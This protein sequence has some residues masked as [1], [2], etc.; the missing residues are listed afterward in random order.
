MLYT[1]LVRF[2]IPNEMIKMPLSMCR[3][4]YKSVLTATSGI[5]SAVL[6]RM[7]CVVKYQKFCKHF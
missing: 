7:Q 3:L 1:F 5:L 2:N 4:N 6:Q